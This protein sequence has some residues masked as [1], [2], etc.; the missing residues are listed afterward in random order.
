M[1]D[2]GTQDARAPRYDAFLGI[3]KA[4]RNF[5]CETLLVVGRLDT[6]D[7]QEVAKA[8]EQTRAL[9]H[10]CESHL[11]NENKHVHPA[12]EARRPGSTAKVALDH[13][14]H[15]RSF[16]TFIQL[17]ADVE[18]ATGSAREGLA[19]YL[20]RKLSVF[21][22]DNFLH[23]NEE[24]I[25]NNRVIWECYAD[26]EI[27]AIEGQIVA[28]LSPEHKMQAFRW[29]I[30]ALTP[31]D[32]SR[33]VGKLRDTMPAPAFSMVAQNLRQFLSARDWERLASELKLADGA[34]A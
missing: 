30:P 8:M 6:A 16:A 29:M 7:D 14:H 20:Y 23:M 2:F 33:V 11:Q 15:E 26:E 5:M 1:S 31:A 17:T 9:I 10:F 3:H 18:Q 24:E 25:E 13:E 32:R 27:M 4:L 28:E 22:A 34:A 21:V 12:M 19:L